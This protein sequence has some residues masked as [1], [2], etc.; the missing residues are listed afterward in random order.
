MFSSTPCYEHIN[1]ATVL[2]QKSQA[3]FQSWMDESKDYLLKQKKLRILDS[4]EEQGLF[5]SRIK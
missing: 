3:E 2:A 4:R 1:A 5:H